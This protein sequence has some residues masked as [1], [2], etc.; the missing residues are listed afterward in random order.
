MI[1]ERHIEDKIVYGRTWLSDVAEGRSPIPVADR[2]RL[3]TLA[4]ALHCQ[5]FYL[6]RIV[7][8]WNAFQA[9]EA[10][11]PKPKP[12]KQHDPQKIVEKAKAADAARATLPRKLCTAC[13]QEKPITEFYEHGAQCK[14]CRRAKVTVYRETHPKPKRKLPGVIL[15]GVYWPPPTS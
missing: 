10:I 15:N 4:F 9:G 5:P 13:G 14:V 6:D 12:K 7:R 2:K 3:R 11:E 1:A 8:E